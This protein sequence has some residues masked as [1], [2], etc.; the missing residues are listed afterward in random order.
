VRVGHIVSLFP[1]ASETFV[2]EAMLACRDKQQEVA[3]WSLRHPRPEIIHPNT[4]SLFEGLHYLAYPFHPR[5]WWDVLCAFLLHPLVLLTGIFRV[6]R[7]TLPD[8]MLWFKNMLSL[9]LGCQIARQARL[10]GVTVF[11][12]H[13]SN[14]PAT[15]AWLASRL[16]GIPLGMHGHGPDLEAQPRLSAAIAVD[17]ELRIIC[18]NNGKQYLNEYAGGGAGDQ[19]DVLH[20]GVD[21]PIRK[22]HHPG[23]VF[24]ILCVGRLTRGK[25]WYAL[26]EALH[27]LKKRRV[28]FSCHMVGYGPE[29]AELERRVSTYGMSDAV[30]FFGPQPN[31]RVIEEM[32]QAHV[33][34]LPSILTPGQR[35]GIPIVILEAMARGVPVVSTNLYGIPEAIEDGE[36]G[37][38]V[39]PDNPNQLADAFERLAQDHELCLNLARKARAKVK[40]E[41][42]RDINYPELAA[43]IAKLERI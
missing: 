4:C 41:F 7:N 3:I 33:F 22:K 21:V 13:F 24:R 12:S 2:V 25:G 38:L 43:R 8:I 10:E 23:K 20:C 29:R 5:F 27:Q 19:F 36:T 14:T 11:Y 1:V 9:G 39:E 30:S 28:K 16:M 17:A 26:V 42:N 15:A 31:P 18:S 34:T 35:E 37:L 32:D 6:T 40:K